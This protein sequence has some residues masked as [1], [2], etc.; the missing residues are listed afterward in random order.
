MSTDL[1]SAAPRRAIVPLRPGRST[2]R[3]AIERTAVRPAWSAAGCDLGELLGDRDDRE[4]DGRPRLEW[5]D[6]GVDHPKAADPADAPCSIDD[7]ERVQ[8]RCH[9]AGA[10][11]VEHGPG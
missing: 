3:V 1:P 8:L 11:R 5:K 10:G 4:V 6:R 2:S 9:P 7:A